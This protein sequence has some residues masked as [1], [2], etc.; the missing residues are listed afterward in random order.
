MS[1]PSALLAAGA[2]EVALVREGRRCSAPAA[3]TVCL[4][5][6]EGHAPLWQPGY[7]YLLGLVQENDKEVL[8]CQISTPPS[9][10]L[11]YAFI[12]VLIE[13]TRHI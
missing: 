10:G 13:C 2:R 5:M 8:L 3:R 11:K 6:S 1:K 7:Q 12:D 4:F 9:F